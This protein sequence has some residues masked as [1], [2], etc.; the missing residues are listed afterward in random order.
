MNQTDKKELL[1]VIKGL[2]GLSPIV[3]QVVNQVKERE[4]IQYIMDELKK[5]EPTLEDQFMYHQD[6]FDDLSDKVKETY[7]GEV[8]EKIAGDLEK[9]FD[10]LQECISRLEGIME[11]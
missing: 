9:A 1:K 7:K 4:Q 11:D 10:N 8:M 6:K 2:K 3:N 5:I